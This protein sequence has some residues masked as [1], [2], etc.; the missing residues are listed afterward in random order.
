MTKFELTDVLVYRPS[1]P[2]TGREPN[3]DTLIFEW[4][5]AKGFSIK[6]ALQLRD[7]YIQELYNEI[8]NR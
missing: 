1:F 5:H 4:Y 8:P 7:N 3:I 6:Q 2:G